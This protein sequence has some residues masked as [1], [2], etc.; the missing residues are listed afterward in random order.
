MGRSYTIHCVGF[1]AGSAMSKVELLQEE[2]R[3]RK[4]GYG[5]I[6]WVAQTKVGEKI[7]S[8]RRWPKLVTCP[9]CEGDGHNGPYYCPVC[10]GSG[11]CR[12]GAEKEWLPWQIEHMR[13]ER[14]K[15]KGG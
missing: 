1:P 11:I 14:N 4:L 3:L 6:T 15:A 8:S 13:V 7:L 12:P 2:H 10:R 5:P 9:I